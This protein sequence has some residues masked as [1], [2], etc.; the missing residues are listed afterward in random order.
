[1]NISGENNAEDVTENASPGIFEKIQRDLEDVPPR[2]VLDFL[3]RYFVIELNW[4]KQIVHPPSFLARY[5]QWC[6][7]E[8]PLSAVA[9]VE[10]TVLVLRVCAYSAQFLPSPSEPIDRIRGLPLSDIRNVCSDIGER[11]A[12]ACVN[13]DWKGSP[14]RVQHILFAALMSS[15]EGRTDKFWEQIGFASQA[16]QKAGLHADIPGTGDVAA[17]EWEREMRRRIFCSLY[18]LDRCVFKKASSSLTKLPLH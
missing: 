7:M 11:L 12:G 15:C 2:E 8:R 18:V 6:N 16:A 17:E 4:M 13:L 10:F 3:V 5:R 14:V 9:D 1:M